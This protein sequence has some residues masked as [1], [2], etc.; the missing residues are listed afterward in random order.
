VKNYKDTNIELHLSARHTEI[1]ILQPCKSVRK[2][3]N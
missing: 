2:A 3:W 1:F